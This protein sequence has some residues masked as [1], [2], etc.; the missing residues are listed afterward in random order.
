M[1]TEKIK[2]FREIVKFLP[3]RGISYSKL[4]EE[5]KICVEFTNSLWKL[6]MEGKVPYIWCHIPNEFYTNKQVS[7]IGGMLFGN[8]L[9]QMGKIKG[10]PDYVFVGKN[11][12]F[13]IE[14]KSLKG[15]LSEEQKIFNGWCEFK[16]IDYFV[17]R[18]AKEGLD[19]ILEYD[20]N[21]K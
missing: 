3:I 16:E 6:E 7:G 2:Y 1:S 17:C 21:S 8:K 14:F 19:I 10:A 13:F 11:G 15:K 5:E 20:E 18:S 4:K 9:T 12:S